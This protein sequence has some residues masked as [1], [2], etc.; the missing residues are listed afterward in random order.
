MTSEPYYGRPEEKN[1]KQ[2]VDLVGKFQNEKWGSFLYLEVLVNDYLAIGDC[3]LENNSKKALYEFFY[4]KNGIGQNTLV[5][6]M[7]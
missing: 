4:G 1:C 7:V 3:L 2:N 5:Q 6:N